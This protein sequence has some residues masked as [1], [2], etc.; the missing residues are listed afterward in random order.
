M[1]TDALTELAGKAEDDMKDV[2]YEY[3]APFAS[4]LDS[5]VIDGDTYL[6]DDLEYDIECAKE[7]EELSRHDHREA[8]AYFYG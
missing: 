7:A 3:H 2:I 4:V 1:N 5:V 6:N 8:H